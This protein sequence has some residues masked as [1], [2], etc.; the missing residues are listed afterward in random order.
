[1]LSCIFLKGA[2]Y[3]FQGRFRTMFKALPLCIPRMQLAVVIAHP[4]AGMK[5]GPV[6]L[7]PHALKDQAYTR[8]GLDAGGRKADGLLIICIKE[9]VYGYGKFTFLCHT[10]HGTHV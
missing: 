6:C 1:M 2:P 9:I 8:S 10:P 5:F 4:V 3:G 7:R